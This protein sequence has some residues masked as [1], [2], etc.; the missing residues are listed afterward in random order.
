M[1]KL[2]ELQIE[3]EST[4]RAAGDSEDLVRS[5]VS[6]NE[7]SE[8]IHNTIK[9]NIDHLSLILSKEEIKA[10]NSPRLVGFQEAVDLGSAFIVES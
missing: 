10:S 2:T 8:E 7:H 9:R 3:V 5:L 1:P 4:I 6:S